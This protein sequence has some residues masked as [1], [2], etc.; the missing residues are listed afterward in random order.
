MSLRS[1]T[2][3]CVITNGEPAST[4]TVPAGTIID[5]DPGSAL[6]TAFSGNLHTLTAGELAAIQGGTGPGAAV[7][8]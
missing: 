5:I 8:N 1:V 2:A 7:S 3:D 4:Y 6:E